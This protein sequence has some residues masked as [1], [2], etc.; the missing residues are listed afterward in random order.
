MMILY[1]FALGM[2][3]S[4][5]NVSYGTVANSFWPGVTNHWVT[6]MSWVAQNTTDDAVFIHWWDYG[7]WIQTLGNRTTVLDGGNKRMPD[8]AAQHYFTSNNVTEYRE[9]LEK[10]GMPT[11]MLVCDDDVLKFYQIARIGL[12]DVWFSPFYAARQLSS[13]QIPG[14]LINTTVF[15]YAVEMQPL[16]G[17]APVTQDMYVEGVLFA[18]GSTY[19][20]GVLLPISQ[21]TVGEPIA[22][23]ANTM[24]GASLMPFNCV[25]IRGIGCNQT[26]TDG[27]PDC[28]LMMNSGVIYVPDIAKDMLITE[29]YVLNKTVPGFKIV[30]DNGVP[31]DMQGISSQS[32]THIQI[33]EIDYDEMGGG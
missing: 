7:Y 22:I 1:V 5:F 26:R 14:D 10:Y 32:R 15:P 3:V 30:Y 12:K 13:S 28:I 17:I 6:A 25:C 20:Q 4:S 8:Y 31:F 24:Y 21:T 19:V 11:H 9:V 23:V 16:S 33:W 2:V 27:V 29:L 18:K